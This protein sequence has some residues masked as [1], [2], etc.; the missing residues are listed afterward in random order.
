MKVTIGSGVTDPQDFYLK[1]IDGL[2]KTAVNLTSVNGITLY[3]R[4]HTTSITRSFT[5]LAGKLTV[6]D[7]A[8]GKV[9][10]LLE[11][12]TLVLTDDGY[13]AYFMVTDS[14]NKLI[15]FPSAGNF[16]IDVIESFAP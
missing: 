12:D 13:D 10:W 16:V 7:A 4:S 8:A 2:T 15:R 6:T 11:A 3:I 5:V 14:S 9:R 1:E